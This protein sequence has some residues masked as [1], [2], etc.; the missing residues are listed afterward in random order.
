PR[1]RPRAVARLVHRDPHQ[2]WPQRRA[3][4]EAAECAVGLYKGV[5][6]G[7]ISVGARARDEISRPEDRLPVPLHDLFV[8][9]HVTTPRAFYE[10]A[11]RKLVE[12][13]RP[14]HHR[15]FYTARRR[16]VPALSSARR[17]R[18]RG[19]RR[20]TPLSSQRGCSRTG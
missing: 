17:P 13:Q 18:T 10:L 15:G 8:S 19:S 16:R 4:P 11:V 5:L 3:G 6:G 20:G 9:A 14:D 2:P 12:I 7:L 1:R